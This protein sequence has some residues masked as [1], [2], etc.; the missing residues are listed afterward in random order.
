MS[1][2]I[3]GYGRGIVVGGDQG[4]ALSIERHGETITLW[5]NEMR[6]G[7]FDVRA[8]MSVEQAKGLRALLDM[9]IQEAE[10]QESPT[11]ER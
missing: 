6:I 4:V 7:G 5:S 8:D 3:I 2:Q 10:T 11:D 1:E 9:A